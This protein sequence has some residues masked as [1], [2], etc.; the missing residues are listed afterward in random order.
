[1]LETRSKIVIETG[2][3]TNSLKELRD[4]IKQAKN[5]MLNA[6]E[7]STAYANAMQKAADKSF[8][9]R[10][11]Q[12]QIRGTARDVG[13]IL[14]NVSKVATGVASGFAAAQGAMGLFGS[15][16]EDLNKALLKVQSAIAL[17]SGLQGLEG[18]GK[19]VKNLG[20]Q[21][22]SFGIVQKTVTTL[23]WAWNAA[24]AANPIGAIVAL[25]AGL[26]AA[27]V[28]LTKAQSVN[29]EETKKATT[30]TDG[31]M[32]ATVEAKE[33]HE[34]FLL[35]MQ[36]LNIE[37]GLLNGSLTDADAAIIRLANTYSEKARQI[38]IDTQMQLAEV[39]GF[40][41]KLEDFSLRLQG[42]E[43]INAKRAEEIRVTGQQKQ[44]E[45][46]KEFNAK[47]EIEHQKSL[48]KIN[49]LREDAKEKD[50]ITNPKNVEK[51]LDKLKKQ[52]T[53]WRIW[54]EAAYEE[55]N[56]ALTD[57]T[58]YSFLEGEANMLNG[59]LQ[60]HIDINNAITNMTIATS[61]TQK[62]I[63]DKQ[64]ADEERRQQ[65]KKDMIWST[66][67]LA[68]MA[69]D[70][71]AAIGESDKKKQRAAVYIEKAAAI[72]S[73]WMN[74]AESVGKSIAASP[75]TAGQPWVTINGV[76]AGAQTALII[77][78]AQQ[79]INGI[80]NSNSDSGSSGAS[81]P[82]TSMQPSA[83][84]IP[85]PISST[86]N[87]LTTDELDLQKQPLRAYVVETELTEVQNRVNQTKQEASF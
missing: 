15:E 43:K 11:M 49:K 55:R 69:S 78:K 9:L 59:R 80:N 76:L 87:I 12:E 79:A 56:A 84:N 81:I 51:D 71:L 27:I 45:N 53:E 54:L 58:K 6:S 20:T 38:A 8:Q 74:Y 75:L 21:L 28:A 42:R 41:D 7:G 33:A 32:A 57:P 72:G 35:T 31:Y 46:L 1:M 22:M 23:Q 70:F 10:E 19:N 34:E 83:P 50:P 24:L 2:E 3:S 36:D 65:I 60:N 62:A 4:E 48:N 86:R 16:S 40:W 25:I 29:I 5:E 77:A 39:T 61:E 68:Y 30:A 13:E 63:L 73:V 64:L 67:D 85:Q 47:M 26:V 18:L 14:G 37:L 82:S 17:A 52:Y 66:I 44:L